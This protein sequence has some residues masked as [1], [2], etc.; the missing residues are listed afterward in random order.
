MLELHVPDHAKIGSELYEGSP[1]GRQVK[2]FG[3]G[4]RGPKFFAFGVCAC[5][6]CSVNTALRTSQAFCSARLIVRGLTPRESQG[7]RREAGGDAQRDPA[8][9]SRGRC[10]VLHHRSSIVRIRF[11]RG[12]PRERVASS[13]MHMRPHVRSISAAPWLRSMLRPIAHARPNRI[14][15]PRPAFLA[16]PVDRVRAGRRRIVPY[17]RDRTAE[18]S[19]GGPSSALAMPMPVSNA[20]TL[21]SLM[22]AFRSRTRGAAAPRS[23]PIVHTDVVADP[24]RSWCQ[25]WPHRRPREQCSTRG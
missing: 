14:G 1:W 13:S 15:H 24:R 21:L 9:R 2:H 16:K 7:H 22:S 8:T 23:R 20:A 10:L 25:Q 19:P 18:S 17:A 6:C 3:L 4:K 5:Q 12:S 11:D